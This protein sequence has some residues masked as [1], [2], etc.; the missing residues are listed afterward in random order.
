MIHSGIIMEDWIG[1]DGKYFANDT[2]DDLS[3][4]VQ[5]SVVDGIDTDTVTFI[6]KCA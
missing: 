4:C 6:T 5:P 2:T 1:L 3:P